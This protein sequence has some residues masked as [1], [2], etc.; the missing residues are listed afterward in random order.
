MHN[1]ARRIWASTPQNCATT[2]HT[3]TF[4]KHPYFQDISVCSKA[5]LYRLSA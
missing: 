2:N 4:E 1:N 5:T 3:E